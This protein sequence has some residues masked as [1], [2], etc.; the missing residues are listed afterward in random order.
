MELISGPGKLDINEIEYP[1]NKP[2]NSFNAV[3]KSFMWWQLPPKNLSHFRLS[4]KN[5]RC[6]ITSQER[7]QPELVH[8]C[9]R[10][11]YGD[12]TLI[13]KELK[14]ITKNLGSYEL[15]LVIHM[16]HI[17]TIFP[18]GNYTCDTVIGI[19]H[20]NATGP[21]YQSSEMLSIIFLRASMHD[22]VWTFNFWV[23]YNTM[24][25]V[26]TELSMWS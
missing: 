1:F 6:V 14:P 15:C 26:C 25:H 16:Y 11:L 22:D 4:I 10:I 8:C 7:Q 18:W 23:Q 3:C 20:V 24:G 21:F 2:I 9:S 5:C 19:I 12:Y 13:S 17:I